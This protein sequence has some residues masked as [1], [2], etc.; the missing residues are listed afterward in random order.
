MK[1]CFCCRTIRR[2]IT[3]FS[4]RMDCLALIKNDS[5]KNYYS[6]QNIHQHTGRK[7]NC[8]LPFG[9]GSKFPR[10]WFFVQKLRVKTLV[11]HSGNFHIAADRN[12]RNAIIRLTYFLA[13]CTRRKS[14][15]ESI[16]THFKKLRS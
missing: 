6:Q 13:E 3:D 8:A 1:S 12:P 2:D 7:N 4:C 15:A 10:L 5:P 16:Y 11:N 14:E 9:F